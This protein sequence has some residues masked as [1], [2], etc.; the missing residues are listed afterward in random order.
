MRITI[1]LNIHIYIHQMSGI[2]LSALCI[3]VPFI[4]PKLY[5]LSDILD[6]TKS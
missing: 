6:E 1:I 2:F 3:L 4:S 5:E